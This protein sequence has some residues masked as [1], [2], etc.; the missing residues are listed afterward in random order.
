MVLR[1]HLNQTQQLPALSH[2]HDHD[3]E[4]HAHT[5]GVIDPEIATSDRGL[6]AVKW[7]FVGL[8]LTALLQVGVFVLSGSIALFADTIHNFADAA[9]AI[10]LG[11]AFWFARRPPTAR[12]AYGYGRVE[13]LAGVVIVAI[14]CFSAMITGYESLDRLF[15]P[16]TMQ[17]IGFVA[18]AAWIGFLGNEVVA[19]FRIRVGQEINSAA[20]VADGY[21]ARIDSLTSLAVLVSAIATWL[22][23]PMADPLIGLCITGAIAKIVVESAQVVFTRLLDGVDPTLTHD[24]HHAV[25][26]V[27]GTTVQQVRSRWIGHQLQVHL[28]LAV[29]SDL[30]VAEAQVLSQSV[31]ARLKQHLPYLRDTIVELE[32]DL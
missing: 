21:H 32:P 11:L 12:F 30:S 4:K 22:G 16:Q 10:P 25:D 18:L 7:S 29:A 8:M 13:D 14:I 31:R 9:T 26:Q 20:L 28:Q 24:I 2:V 15:H 27:K 19:R 17:Q 23:F 1:S 5:H 3:H 6:Q